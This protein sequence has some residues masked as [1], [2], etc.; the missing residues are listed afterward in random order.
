M[1]VPSIN[2][3]HYTKEPYMEGAAR[4]IENLKQWGVEFFQVDSEFDK[5]LK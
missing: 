1:V 2:K 4:D 3:L 5:W